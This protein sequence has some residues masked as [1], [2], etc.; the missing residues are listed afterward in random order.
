MATSYKNGNLFCENVDVE[1]IAQNFGTPVYVYS[2][3]KILDSLFKYQRALNSHRYLICYPVKTNYSLSILDLLN[4]HGCGF[5]IAS[6]GELQRVLAVGGNPEQVV[7]SGV[8]KSK[9][10]IELSLESKIYSIHVESWEELDRTEEISRN[11]NCRAPLGVRVNPDIDAQTHRYVSTGIKDSKFGVPLE[12]VQELYQRI[13][14]SPYLEAKGIH[15]SIGSQLTEL[16][17]LLEARDCIVDLVDSLEILGVKLEYVD[18]G[19]GIGIAYRQGE[20]EPDISSWVQEIVKPV[21]ARGLRLLLEPGRS[22]VG[23]AGILL[24]RVEY[25]K[26][27]VKNFAVVDAALTELIR[28]ALYDGYHHILPSHQHS[29]IKPLLCDVVGPVCEN[30]DFLARDRWL[31]VQQGDVLAILSVGAYGSV[32]SSNYNSR[33]RSAEVIVDGNQVFEIRKRETIAEQI[34][35]EFVVCV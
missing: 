26:K 2:K 22:I 9:K 20:T 32:M 16:S 12:D 5:D 6:E 21:A 30:T 28:P 35:N 31:T 19:G 8:G 23:H 10:E 7:Y 11:L 3:K 25:V 33:F 15:C 27:S 29:N 18:L 34:Q 17:P 24:T 4:R 13:K 1:E 14:H